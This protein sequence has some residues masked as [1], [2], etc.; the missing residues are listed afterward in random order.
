MSDFPNAPN[1]GDDFSH[2][3]EDITQG[4][5]DTTAPEHDAENWPTQQEL[6]D[7]LDRSTWAYTPGGS[8]EEDVHREVS[9]QKRF[10]HHKDQVVIDTSGLEDER[11]LDFGREFSLASREGM[12][13]AEFHKMAEQ[14]VT[15][16]ELRDFID[17]KLAGL[18]RDLEIDKSIDRDD[19]IDR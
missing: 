9:R 19:G 11:E 5:A 15:R 6:D 17:G 10:S 8:L 18:E 12:S 7:H 1:M 16:Q 4:K 13:R 3:T 14:D 2:S